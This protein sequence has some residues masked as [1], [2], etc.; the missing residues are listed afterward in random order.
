[1]VIKAPAPRL[2]RGTQ[3]KRLLTHLALITS[4]LVMLYPFLWMVVGSVKPIDEVANATLV[5]SRLIVSNYVE[6]WNAFGIPFGRFILN[7]FIVAGGCIVGNLLACSLAAFAFARID[8]RLR[9]TWFAIMLLTSMIPYH[10]VLVPQYILFSK[11]GWV[12]TILPLI[13]PKFLATDAFFIFLMVQFIRGIPQELDEAA[14]MDGCGP[15]QIYRRIHLP[16]MRPALATTAIFTFIWTWNDFLTPLIYL[17]DP[18]TYTVPLALASFQSKLGAT[19]FGPLFAMS[20]LSIIPVLACF[21][22]G[23]KYLVR[24]IATTGIK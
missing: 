16:L 10:A 6:G 3:H 11:F 7:S 8:L 15:F 4:G 21:L 18:R 2:S 5:P 9:K 14:T 19:G 23:Q 20:V 24:G 17:I 22:L 1:M 13:V 12:G